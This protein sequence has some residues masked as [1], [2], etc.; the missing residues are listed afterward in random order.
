MKHSQ[1]LLRLLAKESRQYLLQAY[2]GPANGWCCLQ[3]MEMSKLARRQSNIH[4]DT[5]EVPTRSP[6]KVNCLAFANAPMSL[7]CSVQCCFIATATILNT[8]RGTLQVPITYNPIPSP[9]PSPRDTKPHTHLPQPFSPSFGSLPEPR[10]ALRAPGITAKILT[11]SNI[12]EVR[13]IATEYIRQFDPIHVTACLT[14]IVK[15][16]ILARGKR[17]IG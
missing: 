7:F 6:S 17:D 1:H 2:D 10:D 9:M 15:V 12:S 14:K 5:R 4:K 8:G 16:R 11:A 13:M 3:L